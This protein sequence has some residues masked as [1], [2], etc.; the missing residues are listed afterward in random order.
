MK[1]FVIQIEEQLSRSVEIE[2]FSEFDAISKV[3]KLYFEEDLV[4]DENDFVTVVFLNTE[5]IFV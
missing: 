5:T 2:A 1:K 3:R 4:L